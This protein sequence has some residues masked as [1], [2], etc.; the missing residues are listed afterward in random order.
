[1]MRWRGMARAAVRWCGFPTWSFSTTPS[2]DPPSRAGGTTIGIMG[3]TYDPVHSGHL[4]AARQLRGEAGLEQ[5]WLIPNA[6][7][8][9]RSAAPVA[10]PEDR[11][12]MVEI[13]VSD[14]AGLLGSR[15]EVDRGG[16]SYT[17]D[18]MRELA[19]SMPGQR[20]ELLLGSDAALR[21][22]TW[23]EADTL[24]KEVR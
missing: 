22:R 13:A 2:A 4:A 24:L 7:P 17:I 15:I 12:R 19:R 10:S 9:H 23:H 16:I 3:G 1:M 20:F 21:I 6:H 18:T 14:Q 5:V 8:P 11:M